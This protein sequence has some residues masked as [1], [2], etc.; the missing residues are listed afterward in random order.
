M[1]AS[2]NKSKTISPLGLLRTLWRT[3]WL[4]AILWVI[5]YVALL[6][7]GRT[8]GFKSFI[9]DALEK[10][11][12]R[13]VRIASSE[14]TPA[15]NLRLD[16]IATELCG[17][18][19]KP[20]FRA[21]HAAMDWHFTVHGLRVVRLAV[22][23]PVVYFAPGRDN[24]F[25]PVLWEP[26]GSRIAEWG[27]FT[28]ALPAAVTRQITGDAAAWTLTLW[29]QEGHTAQLQV[30]K[31]RLIWWDARNAEGVTLEDLALTLQPLAIPDRN[32]WYV[33]LRYGRGYVAGG[34]DLPACNQEFIE[35]GARRLPLGPVA[36]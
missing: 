28:A 25:E 18:R 5:A 4:C 13:R 20:G 14:L 34:R 32:A 19:G 24:A 12:G 8:D 21:A 33:H 6:L 16:G 29:A 30:N 35:T 26:L 3:A 7:A 23:E 15:L 36:K 1:L 22:D 10:R 9:E 17:E 11:L 2:G 27:Q 31:G